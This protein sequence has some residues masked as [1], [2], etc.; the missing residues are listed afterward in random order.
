MWQV[1]EPVH[2]VTYYAPEA[3]AA[4]DALGLKG[5]WMGYF[6]GCAAPM[7]AVS[8]E[9][10]I[11]TFFNFHPDMVHRALPD[12]W[13]LSS[14]DDVVIA[15]EGAMGDALRRLLGDAID[16]PD[17]AEAAELARSA[18]DGCEPYGRPLY[19]ANAALAWPDEPHLVLWTAATR[20]RE[21][22]G[23]GHVASL[24]GA[25]LDGC[26]A[27][28]TV[29]ALGT[30]PGEMQRANRWWS[31][32]DWAAAERRLI[33]RGWLERDGTLTVHGHA[34]RARLE[35]ATDRAALGPWEHLGKDRTLRLHEL[36]LPLAERVMGEGEVPVPNPVALTWPPVPPRI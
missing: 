10:V 29:A 9:V 36:L 14:P 4:T 12:A 33:E 22:R 21:H 25:G 1:F 11:A 15:R 8:A 23:D 20:L 17:L 26:E 3:R 5:G 7:G 27:H 31:D 16:S 32:D 19:A 2:A 28:V 13:E 35:T 34:E 18:V 30:V 6:A 24:V